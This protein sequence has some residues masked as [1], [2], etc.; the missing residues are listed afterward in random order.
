MSL[1]TAG[2]LQPVSLVNLNLRKDV[3][4]SVVD[5]G[6]N[7]VS[8]VNDTGNQHT[9]SFLDSGALVSRYS[10]IKLILICEYLTNLKKN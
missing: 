10:K 5:T 9:A 7:L 2:N 8:G 4:T 1:L 3:A 6:G